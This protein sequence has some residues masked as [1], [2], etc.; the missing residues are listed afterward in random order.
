M[1]NSQKGSVAV[2]ILVIIVVVL[3]GIV[4]YIYFRQPAEVNQVSGTHNAKNNHTTTG[5][6]LSPNYQGQFYSFSY[7]SGW[8]VWEA[9]PLLGLTILYPTSKESEVSNKTISTTDEITIAI[10]NGQ[11]NTSGT[12]TINLNGQVWYQ[13]NYG[14]KI[15][16]GTENGL[17]YYKSLS[18]TKFIEIT[19]GV[20]NKNQIETVAS[21]FSSK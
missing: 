4:G 13:K 6:N 21:S 5:T 17:S 1:K 7:P 18:L 12:Q 14:T 15:D 3:L 19:S 16:G 11:L 10:V 20:S 9:N 2:I 8:S